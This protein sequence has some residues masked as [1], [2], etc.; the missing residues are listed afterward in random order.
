V[1]NLYSTQGSALQGLSKE[2]D[3]AIETP[4]ATS[5]MGPVQYP[6]FAG[7]VPAPVD[8]YAPYPELSPVSKAPQVTQRTELF[9]DY[10]SD[11]S[12]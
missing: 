4:A 8:E 7:S 2:T 10:Y 11:V 9:L 1:S 12:R 5:D 3:R 6:A